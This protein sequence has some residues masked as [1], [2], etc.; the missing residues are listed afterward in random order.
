MGFQDFTDLSILYAADLDNLMS[1]TVIRFASAAARTTA[2]PTPVAGMATYLTDVQQWQV[3]DGTK[4]VRINDNITWS[5]KVNISM[6]NSTAGQA[7]VT[8]PAGKFSVAPN[9]FAL[10]I[11]NGNYFAYISANATATSVGIGAKHYKDVTA[12]Y[13]LDVYVCAIQTL[14]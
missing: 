10:C 13:A 7:T 9:I 4:W 12:T 6:T 11:G 1:Q 3:Y 14:A 8:F 5:T 2:L